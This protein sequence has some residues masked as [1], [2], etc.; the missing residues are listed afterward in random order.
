MVSVLILVRTPYFEDIFGLKNPSQYIQL[1]LVKWYY[2]SF[3]YDYFATV[4]IITLVGFEC[5][6]DLAEPLLHYTLHSMKSGCNG[7]F[8]KKPAAR[9]KVSDSVPEFATSVWKVVC[10]ILQCYPEHLSARYC[11][12]SL[13]SCLP[14]IATT[15]WIVGWWSLQHQPE[16]LSSRYWK[17]SMNICLAEFSMP[18]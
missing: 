4:R 16:L 6:W 12:I 18:A 13:N 11:T 17:N 3:Q 2:F 8:W 14:D 5:D 9:L 10:Q 1:I 7:I 15:A